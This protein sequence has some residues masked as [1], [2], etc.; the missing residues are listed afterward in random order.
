MSTATVTIVGTNPLIA[1]LNKLPNA[2]Q[3][4]V[5]RPA[6]RKGARLIQ[7]AAQG[8][9]PVDTGLMRRSLTVKAMKTKKNRIGSMVMYRNVDLLLRFSKAGKRYFYPA[10][11]EYGH[12]GHDGTHFIREAFD[13]KQASAES[14]ILREIATGIEREAALKK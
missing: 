12:S 14:M 2:V 9:A 13:S 3:K 5:L 10:A 1:K 8:G 7:K 4:R 6:L 11:V